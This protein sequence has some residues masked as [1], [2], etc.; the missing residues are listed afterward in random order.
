MVLLAFPGGRAEV[1]GRGGSPGAPVLGPSA[2]VRVVATASEAPFSPSPA[3][4]LPAHSMP[5]EKPDDVSAKPLAAAD[6]AS[7]PDSG[8]ERP[9]EETA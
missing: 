4:N 6:A 1:G 7:G 5:P 8:P 9:Q 3:P 2:G